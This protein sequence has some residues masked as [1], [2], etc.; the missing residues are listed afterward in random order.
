MHTAREIHQQPE[1]WLKV[2][3]L[4]FQQQK[5]IRDFLSPILEAP[6]PSILLS[7]AGTSAFIGEALQGPFQ[8]AAG[9]PVRAVPTTNLVSHPRQFFEAGRPTL[10]ASFA[11]SGNS[12]ES[13]AAI[14]MG[15]TLCRD[16][17]HLI[18][19]CNPDGRMV[20]DTEGLNRYVFLLP[21]AN[22]QG[23]AMTSSFTSMLLAGLLLSRIDEVEAL[24][25]AVQTLSHYAS[26]VLSQYGPKLEAVADIGFRRA[27]FL[28]SGPLLG[29]ANEAHLKL[30]EL[31]D[32][33]VICKHDSFIGFRHG[34]K[35]VIDKHTLMVYHFSNDP[36]VFQYEKDLLKSVN[37]GV[38]GIYSIGI[39]ENAR[40]PLDVN[41]LIELSGEGQH[42]PEP[43]MALASVLPAQM[44]GF[45][46]SMQLGLNPDNP[47]VSG[48]ITRVVQGVTIYPME[49]AKLQG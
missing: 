3:G 14:Q 25:G 4:V 9:K 2:W 8:Q 45:F 38:R 15:A 42:I 5:A 24:R 29:I 11:R 31:T 18:I 16:I 21:E 20:R 49:T 26:R 41:L 17:R 40:E 22:D 36:Y 43:F 19:T 27:V 32:G 12:P 33:Q 23:L 47:S 34:P 30:Q 39:V 46:K 7:G 44:L 28:G 6:C 1:L 35:A 10:L 37:E 48:A 13:L